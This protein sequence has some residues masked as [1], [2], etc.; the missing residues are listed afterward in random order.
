LQIASQIVTFLRGPPPDTANLSPDT[1][2]RPKLPPSGIDAVLKSHLPDAQKDPNE[3]PRDPKRAPLET[4]FPP[5]RLEET[6]K[7]TPQLNYSHARPNEQPRD[8][9]GHP[10]IHPRDTKLEALKPNCCH[11]GLRCHFGYMFYR[12]P[13]AGWLALHIFHDW[14]NSIKALLIHP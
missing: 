6:Q 8:T 4:E 9:K 2:F 3:H 13:L 11:V 10:F 14:I 5:C 1:G 7:G 12:F